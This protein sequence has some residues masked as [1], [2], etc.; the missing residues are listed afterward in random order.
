MESFTFNTKESELSAITPGGISIANYGKI[1]VKFQLENY[2]MTIKVA[3]IEGKQS[4]ILMSEVD[5]ARYDIFKDRENQIVLIKGKPVS[6]QDITQK[7]FTNLS[8]RFNHRNP[9]RTLNLN[10]KNIG[11]EDES[12]MSAQNIDKNIQQKVVNDK[13]NAE[14]CA[15]SYLARKTGDLVASEKNLR[16]APNVSIKLTQIEPNQPKNCLMTNNVSRKDTT[17]I[18]TNP[19]DTNKIQNNEQ[20]RLPIQSHRI[21]I[22]KPV[23]NQINKVQVLPKKKL[24]VQ[25]Q[26]A[27]Q[28]EKNSENKNWIEEKYSSNRHHKFIQN[29]LP[30]LYEKQLKRLKEIVKEN[31]KRNKLIGVTIGEVSKEESSQWQEIVRTTIITQSNLVQIFLKYENNSYED[32]RK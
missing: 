15:T 31:E 12:H 22:V 25:F 17:R 23:T 20:M 1:P 8:H 11:K 4:Y 3:V 18:Q 16:L 19:Y 2:L 29:L 5:Q 24:K 10:I 26:I 9:D 27:K 32:I 28:K 7:Q 13:N 30:Q 21:A 14:T 6:Y